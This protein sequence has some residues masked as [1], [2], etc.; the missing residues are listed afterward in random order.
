MYVD[1]PRASYAASVSRLYTVAE[2]AAWAPEKNAGM[3]AAES[4]SVAAATTR[5][6]DFS[7]VPPATHALCMGPWHPVAFRA[8]LKVQMQ[9]RQ[10]ESLS[11][12]ALV[13]QVRRR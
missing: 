1:P 7:A 2:V 13:K 4:P 12:S 5:S 3:I 11:C 10:I 6:P 8:H 9:P